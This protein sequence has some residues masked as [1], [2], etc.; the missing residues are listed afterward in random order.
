MEPFP[1]VLDQCDSG[2]CLLNE[3][4]SSSAIRL[5][6]SVNVCFFLSLFLSLSRSVTFL[7]E[8]RGSLNKENVGDSENII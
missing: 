5:L 8:M 6:V 2:Q 3:R 7:L 1:E 4:S